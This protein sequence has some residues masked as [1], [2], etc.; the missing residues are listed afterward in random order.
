M[1]YL[2][3]YVKKEIKKNLLDYLV[4]LTA[5]VFFIISINLF[6]GERI[7]EFIVLLGFASFYTI[8][9]LYH[10]IIEDT[11]HLKTVVEYILIAFTIVFF[12]KILIL[13]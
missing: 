1:K 6:R 2:I 11:L 8:W 10:H 12:L 3:T 4:L 13:P 7:F 5:G 9:G